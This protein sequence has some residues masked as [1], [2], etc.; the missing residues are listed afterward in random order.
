VSSTTLEPRAPSTASSTGGRAVIIG[1]GKLG[2]GYLAPLFLDAAWHTVLVARTQA[3]ADRIKACGRFRIR[4]VPGGETELPSGV[5]VAFGQ[6]EFRKAVAEADVVVTAV[7][8]E[9]VPALGP[10]LALALRER[11]SNSPID[12]LV[13]ENANVAPTLETSVR[14][15]AS[16]AGITLPPVGFAGAIAYPIVACGDWD[17]AT[18]P[19][20]V[21]DGYDGLLVDAR[22]LVGTLPDLRGVAATHDYDARLCEKLYVFSAGHALCAYLGAPCGYERLDEAARDPLVRTIVKECLVEAR[23]ALERTH[24]DLGDD[25]W[26]AVTAAMRRYENEGLRDPIRRVARSPLRKLAPDGPL[27]GGAKLVRD[28]FGR[29]STSYALGV[30]SGLLYRDEADAQA[31]ELDVML[32]RHRVEE[33][34]ERVC[35][36][37]PED[38]F[39]RA[40][41]V[42][43]ERMHRSRARIPAGRTR[44]RRRPERRVAVAPT[45]RRWALK[46][47]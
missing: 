20:F 23:S 30:A 16:T 34:I 40:V 25:G 7:G 24:P 12:V 28:V 29:A 33:V 26:A 43:Y 22:R 27:I 47:A 46:A 38:A 10:A 45:T 41:V 18:A 5:A 36:L 17:G 21:R 19:T 42:A 9:N 32:R 14:R 2:C 3:R 13:V 15:A 11:G 39:S 6:A 31:R 37:D 4:R 1:P 35:G 8:V 44:A